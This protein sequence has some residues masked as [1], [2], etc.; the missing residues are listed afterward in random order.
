[1][2]RPYNKHKYSYSVGY[3]SKTRT[4][5]EYEVIQILENKKGVIRFVDSGNVQIASL[6]PQGLSFAR[7]YSC[8]NIMV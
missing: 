1:M 8:E 3:K 5:K 7:D 4:G 6:T 2:S